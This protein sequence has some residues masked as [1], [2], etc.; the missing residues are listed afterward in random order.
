MLDGNTV[1]CEAIESTPLEAVT[2]LCEELASRLSLKND[3][4]P[5]QTPGT[6]EQSRVL[7][8][9]NWLRSDDTGASSMTIA[10]VAVNTYPELEACEFPKNYTWSH[11]HDASDFA[12]C[13][14]LVEAAPFL[15][16][17]LWRLRAISSSWKVVI[18]NWHRWIGVLETYGAAALSIEMKKDFN[19]STSVHFD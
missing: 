8:L 15:Q 11:P 1:V 2:A 3:E 18:A 7:L 10:K 9:N 16:T 19:I 5:S 4:A 14:R 17:V 6:L 13:V 12:R